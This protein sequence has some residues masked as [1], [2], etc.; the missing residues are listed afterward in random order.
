MHF[1]DNLLNNKTIVV[2][3][4][5]EYRLILVNSAYGL[6]GEVSDDFFG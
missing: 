6:A 1:I 5:T 4:I 3:N 2:L